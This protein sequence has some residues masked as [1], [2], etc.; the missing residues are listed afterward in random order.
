MRAR[1]NSWRFRPSSVSTLDPFSTTC[2][3]ASSWLLAFRVE[4]PQHNCTQRRATCDDDNFRHSYYDNCDKSKCRLQTHEIVCFEL[5]WS[6]FT[7]TNR[8]YT[9]G[10]LSSYHLENAYFTAIRSSIRCEKHINM[11]LRRKHLL[12]CIHRYTIRTKYV[13]LD[14]CET[15]SH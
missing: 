11:F 8:L 10:L 5:L 2:S 15:N 3:G 4:H 7:I 12:V 1:S 6:M 9:N 14:N 13:S